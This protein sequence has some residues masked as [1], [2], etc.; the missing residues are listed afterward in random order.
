MSEENVQAAEDVVTAPQE[1]APNIALQDLVLVAQII[2]LTATRGGFRAEELETVGALYTKLVAFLEASGAVRQ[3]TAEE[4]T[5]EE[6][7]AESD[8]E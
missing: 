7:T 2:Q 5:A 8:S 3:E 4:V 1:V 6:V